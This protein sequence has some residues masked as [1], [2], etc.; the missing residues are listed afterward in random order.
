IMI[1]PTVGYEFPLTPTLAAVAEGCLG[2][3]LRAPIF[4]NGATAG[5]M[6]LPVTGW[7]MAGRF[8]YPDVGG[9]ITWQ[10]SPVLAATFRLQLFYPIFDLWGGLPW[11][12]ELTY[13]AG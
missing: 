11:Y 2:F 1:N 5:D 6:A 10:F 8:I 7:L 3:L 4:P 12:D 13:G 9:S